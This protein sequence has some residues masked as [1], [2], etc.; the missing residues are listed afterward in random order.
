MDYLQTIRLQIIC[1]LKL[2]S[3]KYALKIIYDIYKEDL[4]LNKPQ[5]WLWHKTRLNQT[6]LNSTYT[7]IQVRLYFIDF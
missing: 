1:R 5:C 3:T 2:L 7:H 6:K 4:V